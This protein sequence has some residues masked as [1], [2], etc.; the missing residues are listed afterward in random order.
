MVPPSGGFPPVGGWGGE[1]CFNYPG[2]GAGA[3]SGTG[4][5]GRRW[6]RGGGGEEDGDTGEL[7]TGEQF[8]AS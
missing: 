4:A 3:G 6:M 7:R 8:D 2:T 5:E 1:D